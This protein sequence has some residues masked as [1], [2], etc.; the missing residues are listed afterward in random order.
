MCVCGCVIS[1]AV[2]KFAAMTGDLQSLAG[3]DLKLIALA[4]TLEEKR[5]EACQTPVVGL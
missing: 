3:T 5:C 1:L 2:K 4:Y